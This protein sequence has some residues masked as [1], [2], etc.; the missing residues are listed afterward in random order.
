MIFA[1]ISTNFKSIRAL[2]VTLESIY[3]QVDEIN[4]FGTGYK[5][6][7]FK[8]K[9]INFVNSGET[10][11]NDNGRFFFVDKINGFYF[12]ISDN[13]I[14]PNNYFKHLLSRMATYDIV[15]CGGRNFRTFPIKSYELSSV[16]KYH[17]QKHLAKDRN[18]QF[19]NTE[20]TAFHTQDFKLKYADFNKRDMADVIFSC[21]A[22][23]QNKIITCLAK[24]DNWIIPNIYTVK[25]KINDEKTFYVNENF[26][27]K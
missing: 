27:K 11:I 25:H 2:G 24:D 3:K 22:K 13:V 7:P 16:D 14:Y 18:V 10:T 21:K 19:A 12:T 17:F 20:V 15:C 4:I 1:N 8:D 5:E 6:N 23:K 26:K 9:K